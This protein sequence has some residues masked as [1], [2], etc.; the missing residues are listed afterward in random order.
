MAD[1]SHNTSRRRRLLSR[2]LSEYNKTVLGFVAI[3]LTIAITAGLVLVKFAGLGYR[4]YTAQFIQA[5]AL[6]TGNIVTVAGIPVGEVTSMRLAG[7]HVEATLRVRDNIHLGADTKAI[8]KITTILGS[9][10]VE[11]R[12][13]HTGSLPNRVIDLAHTE[14]PYDLQDTLTDVTTTFDDVDTDQI[15][16]SLGTLGKQLEGLSSIVPQ[17]MGDL[18][19][20]SAIVAK[21]RNQIGSLLANIDTVTTTL[22]RQQKGMGNLVRQGQDLLGEFVARQAAFHVL[23]QSTTKLVDFLSKTVVNDEAS[24]EDLIKD[25]NHLTNLLASHDDLVRNILQIAPVTARNITNAFGYGNA[26]EATVTNGAFVDSWMCAISGRAKQFG[27]I[28]YYKDCK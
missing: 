5:A 21:R 23:A 3:G 26:M 10:Y 15:A 28:E 18:E 4:S 6:H 9:R 20:L 7:D 22:R 24:I 27:M 13:G 11:V 17:A 19:T 12:P 14:V 1:T 16:A 25:V 8:M 2:P